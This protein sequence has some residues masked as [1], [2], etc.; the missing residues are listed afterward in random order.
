M[1]RS[2]GSLVSKSMTPMNLVGTSTTP[3]MFFEDVAQDFNFQSSRPLA[4]TSTLEATSP[5]FMLN[6][7]NGCIGQ[8]SIR[9]TN[10]HQKRDGEQHLS[11]LISK[12]AIR[13][14]H[15]AAEVAGLAFVA[16][17]VLFLLCGFKKWCANGDST[18]DDIEALVAGDKTTS[19]R[20]SRSW[21]GRQRRGQSEV[22]GSR[23]SGEDQSKLHIQFHVQSKEVQQNVARLQNELKSTDSRFTKFFHPIASLHV[24]MLVVENLEGTDLYRANRALKNAAKVVRKKYN[25]QKLTIC[26]DGLSSFSKRNNQVLY[27]AASQKDGSIQKLFEIKEILKAQFIKEDIS[28]AHVNKLFNP[29]MTIVNIKEPKIND[30]ALVSKWESFKSRPIYFG[31][32]LISSFELSSKSSGKYESLQKVFL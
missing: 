28:V 10:F 32:E 16:L 17:L 4:Y 12:I 15:M 31:T 6:N 30:L 11:Q 24:T 27:A 14:A 21:K 7:N 29:H 26:F 1:L 9:S 8:R 2:V 23:A 5:T 25:G 19:K 3:A 13:T 22:P 20:R 18:E